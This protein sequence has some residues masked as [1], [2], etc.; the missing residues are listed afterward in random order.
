MAAEEWFAYAELTD[1]EPGQV[2]TRVGTLTAA[3]HNG[4]LQFWL[5]KA[6]ITPAPAPPESGR[7]YPRG[8]P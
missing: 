4:A 3:G 1:P 2:G 6:G 5:A 8:T 7:G